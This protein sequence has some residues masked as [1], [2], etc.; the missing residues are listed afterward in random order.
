MTAERR[1]FYPLS[2]AAHQL[3][4]SKPTLSRLSKEHPFYEPS[5]RGF[6]GA[7]HGGRSVCYHRRHLELIAAVRVGAM[8]VD[9]ALTRWKLAKAE[10]ATDSF[11]TAEAED[12]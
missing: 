5:A 4:I 6:P 8:D 9:E 1:L 7:D 3:G 11:T 10:M 12:E 2:D